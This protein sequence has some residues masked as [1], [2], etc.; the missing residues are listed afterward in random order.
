[1]DS[2]RERDE[3][4]EGVKQREREGERETNTPRHAAFHGRKRRAGV[5]YLF[6]I[7]VGLIFWVRVRIRQLHPPLPL[8]GRSTDRRQK[9]VKGARSPMRLAATPPRGHNVFMDSL[10]HRGGFM[11]S[12]SLHFEAPV[13]AYTRGGGGG[14]KEVSTDA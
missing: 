4:R 5:Q 7:V 8:F 13:R 11:L 14:G 10:G 12:V 1:M 9:E 6:F 2:E 3:E